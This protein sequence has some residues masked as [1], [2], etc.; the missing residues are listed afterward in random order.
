MELD[1]YAGFD[2]FLKAKCEHVFG[3]YKCSSELCQRSSP[4]SVDDE[5][6]SFLNERGSSFL[7]FSITN[8]LG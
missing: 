5:L 2:R 3:E 4:S 8:N 1:K 6:T 7:L